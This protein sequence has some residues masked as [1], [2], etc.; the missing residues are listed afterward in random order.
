MLRRATALQSEWQ[1]GAHVLNVSRESRMAGVPVSDASDLLPAVRAALRSPNAT[2]STAFELL[3]KF[4]ARL[5]VLQPL[6]FRTHG[7]TCL[8][9]LVRLRVRAR[10][11]R[12]A[13]IA[14]RR[15]GQGSF[16][17]PFLYQIVVDT[18][19]QAKASAH[20][21]R[22][23]RVYMQ[24]R[25]AE[26][27]SNTGVAVVCDDVATKSL[28]TLADFCDVLS[29]PLTTRYGLL[30]CTVVFRKAETL[31][32]GML[33]ERELRRAALAAFEA[34]TPGRVT[35]AQSGDWM[36]NDETAVERAVDAPTAIDTALANIGVTLAPGEM[37]ATV[38]VLLSADVTADESN[39]STHFF[40]G[41]LAK[42]WP[43][44]RPLQT[45]KPQPASFWSQV[46]S[47]M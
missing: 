34:G 25:D 23:A 19:D 33:P 3:R 44:S 38:S 27:R 8:A 18:M 46:K 17:R 31:A 26:A 14:A 30:T 45:A 35:R 21:F 6:V 32:N 40:S 47:E 9:D 7:H 13:L 41:R 28:A 24:V 1:R 42:K 29:V 39:S 4:N 5:G 22:S 43:S 15:R 37:A 2:A 10:L 11:D 36:I 12:R 20:E 16:E